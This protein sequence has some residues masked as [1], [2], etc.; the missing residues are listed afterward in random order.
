MTGAAAVVQCTIEALHA[1]FDLALDYCDCGLGHVS[2]LY[3]RPVSSK[4]LFY[5]EVLLSSSFRKGFPQ[6]LSDA[7][8]SASCMKRPGGPHLEAMQTAL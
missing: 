1:G 4:F 3:Q 8:A 6:L 5:Q 7:Q 2:R